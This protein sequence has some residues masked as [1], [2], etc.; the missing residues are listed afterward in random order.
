M[1]KYDYTLE[2]KPGR[3]F[4]LPDM[5]SRAPLRDT[6]DI[7]NMEEEIALHVHLIQSSLPVSKLKLEEIREETAKDESLKDLIENI[8]RWW[9]EAKACQCIINITRMY[10]DVRD[11]LSELNGIILKGERILI[12]TS[13]RKEMLE[14]IHQGH[15]GKERSKQRARDVLHWPVM[16][17]EIQEKISRCSICQQHQKQNEKEPMIPS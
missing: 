11:E 3:E 6:T 4:L 17:S 1:Q 13:T 8:K 14:R 15:M 10:W 5:L 16:G 2:Y 9:S 7:N 12:P